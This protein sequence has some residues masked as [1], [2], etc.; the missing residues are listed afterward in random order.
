MDSL[1]EN[2]LWPRFHWKRQRFLVDLAH[3]QNGRIQAGIWPETNSTDL[4]ARIFPTS[5]IGLLCHCGTLGQPIREGLHL[6]TVSHG[7]VSITSLFF[8]IGS[9]SEPHGLRGTLIRCQSTRTSPLMRSV[10]LTHWYHQDWLSLIFC[11]MWVMATLSTCG[12]LYCR[13]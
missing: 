3:L 8:I 12:N 1:V 11:R 2:F 10:A 4:G 13:V 9:V 7:I 5:T 6:P